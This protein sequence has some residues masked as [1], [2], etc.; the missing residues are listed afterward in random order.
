M[1]HAE[2]RAAAMRRAAGLGQRRPGGV[3]QRDIER[4]G[5]AGRLPRRH[6]RRRRPRSVSASPIRASS[7]ARSAAPSKPDGS[8]IFLHRL[9]LHE[10]PLAGVDRVERRASRAPAPASPPRCRTARRRTHRAAG[11]APPPVALVLRPDASG[12]ARAASRRACSA[13]SSAASRARNTRSSRTSPSRVASSA[14]L[15]PASPRVGSAGRGISINGLIPVFGRGGRRRRKR[16]AREGGWLPQ[17]QT[18][19]AGAAWRSV[20]GSR[21]P[22]CDPEANHWNQAYPSASPLPRE[23]ERS[24]CEARG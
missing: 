24:P 9:A 19:S 1:R 13:A 2:Q 5:V 16:C 8:A 10:Q 12:A 17:R 7:A 20:P 11:R 21:A 22:E 14:K 18:S 3:A 23:R 15:K 4:L 6:V